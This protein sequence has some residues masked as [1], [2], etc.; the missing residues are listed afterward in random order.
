ML[1]LATSDA[2]KASEKQTF[3]KPKAQ[4]ETFIIWANEL[5]ILDAKQTA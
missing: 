2:V 5:L 1:P 3:M 4:P